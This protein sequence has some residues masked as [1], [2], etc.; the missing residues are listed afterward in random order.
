MREMRVLRLVVHAPTREPVLLLGEVAGDRFL[1]VFLRQHQAQVIAL[2]PRGEQDPMI[3]QDLIDTIVRGLGH[4]MA[5]VEITELRDGVFRSD[6][7]FDDGSRVAL[8]PSDALAV[9]IRDGLQI[10]V[11]DAILDEVGQLTSD[12]FPDGT[13]AP[14]EEQLRD[15]GQF[16]DEVRPEDFRDPPK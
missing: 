14:P 8:R 2:G 9:A 6:L 7:V 10:S 16:I 12:V 3:G 5:G 4:T 13:E 15:F 1:P 11:A